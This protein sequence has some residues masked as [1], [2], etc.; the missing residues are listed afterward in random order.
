MSATYSVYGVKQTDD[1]F[2]KMKAIYDTCQEAG[3]EIPSEVYEYFNHE[4]PNDTGIVI[5][6]SEEP[7]VTQFHKPGTSG[8][9]VKLSDIPKGLTH[10][11]FKMSY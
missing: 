11:R 7:Y 10:I 2:H 1:R 4:E 9:D 6:L 8:F 5:R 3:V